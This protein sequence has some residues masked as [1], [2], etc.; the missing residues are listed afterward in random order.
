MDS[1]WCDDNIVCTSF[2]MKYCIQGIRNCRCTEYCHKCIHSDYWI[3]WA[4]FLEISIKIGSLRRKVLK[5]KS[6][7]ML[8]WMVIENCWKLL[9]ILGKYRSQGSR[10]VLKSVQMYFLGCADNICCTYS[11]IKYWSP[12]I[13]NNPCA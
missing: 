5:I 13:R 2:L 12:G 7:N 9:L 8:V 6:I 4:D 1:L 10:Y 11:L 3:N